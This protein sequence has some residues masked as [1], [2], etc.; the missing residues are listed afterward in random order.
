M[1]EP[2][3]RIVRRRGRFEEGEVVIGEV[4]EVREDGE[5]DGKSGQGGSNMGGE[6]GERTVGGVR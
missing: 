4:E 1:P 5:G 2:M 3:S 6:V